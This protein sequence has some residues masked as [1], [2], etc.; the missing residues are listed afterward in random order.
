MFNRIIG[1]TM[2]IFMLVAQAGQAFAVSSMP[3]FGSEASMSMMMA[4]AE[5]AQNK[6]NKQMMDHEC[7]QQECDC[8]SGLLSL[9][10]LFDLDVQAAARSN[11][12]P[13]VD[14]DSRL[15]YTFIPQQKRPPISLFNLAA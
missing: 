11:Y 2:I 4:A 5:D 14:A 9:A 8:P 1:I 10:V 12:E 3:C 7:C 6:Q 15:I 13:Q